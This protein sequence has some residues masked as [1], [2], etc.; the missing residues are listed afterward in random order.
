MKSARHYLPAAAAARWPFKSRVGKSREVQHSGDVLRSNI[1][2]GKLAIQPSEVLCTVGA[3]RLP[4]YVE[5]LSI[6][7]R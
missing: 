6:A 7:L 4:S 5:S 2:A 1:Q 3:Y